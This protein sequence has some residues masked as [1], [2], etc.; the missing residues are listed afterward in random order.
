[1]ANETSV[2][3]LSGHTFLTERYAGDA[4]RK[5]SIHVGIAERYD[6]V[7]PQAGGP[8]LQPGDYIHFN[9]RD[10]HFAEGA[11]GILR[12]YEKE[13]PDLQK[14]PAGYTSRSEIPKPLPVCP[15]DA[16]VRSFNV[17]AISN[18]KFKW[19][20]RRQR[21]THWRKTPRKLRAAFNRCR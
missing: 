17:V 5:N 15:S 18:V 16:P 6:L 13:V 2:W 10:S 19:P 11:W 14:L 4:N 21:S 9:G 1:M 20:I 7:V 12:V 3:T 8:R